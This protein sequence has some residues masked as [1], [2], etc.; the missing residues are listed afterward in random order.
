MA[1]GPCSV[2]LMNLIEADTAAHK[3]VAH[4]LPG[5]GW[6][7]RWNQNKGR[8]G[9]CKHDVR[10]LEFSAVLFKH[11]SDDEK[12]DTILHEIAHALVGPGFGHGPVWKRAARE[13][14]C[15]GERTWKNEEVNAAVSKWV[16]TCQGCGA[17]VYRNRL[18][19]RIKQYGASHPPCG[20]ERG[21]FTIRQ[22]A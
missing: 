2:F 6:R 19:S 3:L 10:T 13:I 14:G 1:L 12:I 11:V 21:Q 22:N 4:H 15:S 18:S 7:V 20:K 8:M 16:L 5:Q 17:K 9:V